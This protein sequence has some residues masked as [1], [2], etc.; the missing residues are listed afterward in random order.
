M[1]SQYEEQERE[2]VHVACKHICGKIYKFNIPLII[3]LT[4][5]GEIIT[6]AVLGITATAIF[7]C[8]KN[9]KKILNLFLLPN[10]HQYCLKIYE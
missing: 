1:A 6:K 7:L 10:G 9:S 4:I 5:T 2:S 8:Y 3:N